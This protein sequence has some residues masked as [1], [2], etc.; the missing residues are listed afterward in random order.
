[1]ASDRRME[2]QDSRELETAEELAPRRQSAGVIAVKDDER[3][4]SH[5]CSHG[6]SD[7]VLRQR[8]TVEDI[9]QQR[10]MD[11]S[12]VELSGEVTDSCL[13]GPTATT[14]SPG[15]PAV[16][17]H[18][19]LPLHGLLHPVL[20]PPANSPQLEPSRSAHVFIICNFIRQ[21]TAQK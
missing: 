5:R 11:V 6:G 8:Q 2:K 9:T 19:P 15:R 10:L 16:S 17:L 21:M 12:T 13:K 7:A 3:Q 4:R 18:D 20:G 1:M 14:L